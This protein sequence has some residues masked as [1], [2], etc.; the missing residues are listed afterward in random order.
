MMVSHM[1]PETT[2]RST[3]TSMHMWKK[4]SIWCYYRLLVTQVSALLTPAGS[5]SVPS[6]RLLLLHK[7]PE[8]GDLGRLTEE[9]LATRDRVP[10]RNCSLV[11]FY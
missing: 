11:T 2:S 8:Q 6:W 4:G 7:S 9:R 10:S 3:V 1:V 5:L